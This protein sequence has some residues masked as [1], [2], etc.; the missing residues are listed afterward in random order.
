MI[1]DAKIDETLAKFK[2]P[3]QKQTITY[4]E[5]KAQINFESQFYCFKNDPLALMAE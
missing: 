5:K 1:N 4:Q 2:D 3:D